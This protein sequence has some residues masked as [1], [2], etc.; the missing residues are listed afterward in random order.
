MHIRRI[1]TSSST[2]LP[3]GYFLENRD[4][5]L[6]QVGE[7]VKHQQFAKRE[8][9]TQQALNQTG[10]QVIIRPELQAH[11]A[12]HPS[13]SVQQLMSVGAHLGHAARK[14]NPRMAPFLHG[15]RAG[16]HI[17]DLDKTVVCL[18]VAS[19]AIRE[20]V[21]CG[22]KVLWVGTR[23]PLRRLTYECAQASKQP[24]INERWLGGTITNR[25]FVL[26]QPDLLPDLVVV[27]DYPNN[28]VALRECIKEGIPTMAIV[29][30]DCD[31]S[32][33]TYPIPANDDAIASVELIARALCT[34]A[35]Q[36]IQKRANP[37]ADMLIA[38]QA[39]EIASNL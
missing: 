27:L 17:I 12:S 14:W 19:R 6:R 13:C 16:I 9:R 25:Q 26:R 10:S 23:Q 3:F 28:Q 37:T 35:Q 38:E 30:S 8:G 29:D 24:Y 15:E 11:Y 21:A 2:G 1:A 22:G 33:V 7:R 20:I 39:Q 18:R 5:F 4:A 31:P 34:A 32:L 36:G